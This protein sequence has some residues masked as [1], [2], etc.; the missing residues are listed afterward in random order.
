MDREMKD[1]SENQIRYEAAVKML[2]KKFNMLKT[3]I[4]ERA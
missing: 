4:N 2:T 1:L 3:V